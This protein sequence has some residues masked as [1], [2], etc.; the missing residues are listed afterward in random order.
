MDKI[1][2]ILLFYA[3]FFS[4]FELRLLLGNDEGIFIYNCMLFFFYFLF[5]ILIG[6]NK[7]I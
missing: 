6:G 1:L 4:F 7:M 5:N 2:Y 3:V